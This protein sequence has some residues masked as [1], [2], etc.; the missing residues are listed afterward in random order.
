[1]S[2]SCLI[3]FQNHSADQSPEHVDVGEE[4]A[5]D[6]VYRAKPSSVN[7][8]VVQERLGRINTGADA[9]AQIARPTSTSSANRDPCPSCPSKVRGTRLIYACNSFASAGGSW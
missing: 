2:A 3:S 7:L 4:Y 9:R 1:M 6:V 8:M 5:D